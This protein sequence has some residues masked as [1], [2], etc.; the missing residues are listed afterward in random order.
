MVRL[1]SI[2]LEGVQPFTANY[3]PNDV[4]KKGLSFWGTLSRG[5]ALFRTNVFFKD[6]MKTVRRVK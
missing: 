5:R 6:F 2:Q 4:G 3:P 1:S